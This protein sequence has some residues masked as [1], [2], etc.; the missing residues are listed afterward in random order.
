M[1]EGR[2]SLVAKLAAI[3]PMRKRTGG[4]FAASPGPPTF[5]NHRSSLRA[6]HFYLSCAMTPSATARPGVGATPAVSPDGHN[7]SGRAGGRP[8]GGR[9]RMV[10][11]A[12][13]SQ[14]L[15]GQ[16]APRRTAANLEPIHSGS[17]QHR[18]APDFQGKFQRN[19]PAGAT[20][21]HSPLGCQLS[22]EPLLSPASHQTP[23]APSPP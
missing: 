14:R 15:G 10:R 18:S 8:A 16:N 6:F 12:G 21:G 3:N 17:H 19:Q 1:G 23:G 13:R 22:A 20:T 9:L 7:T 11:P 2:E 5:P 4:Y